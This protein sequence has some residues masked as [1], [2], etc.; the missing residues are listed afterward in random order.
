M[1]RVSGDAKASLNG[2]ELLSAGFSV[3]VPCAVSG[4]TPQPLYCERLLRVLPGKRL[5]FL[6]RSDEGLW[7]VKLMARNRRGQQQYQ[8]E[9]EGYHALRSANLAVPEML[10][11]ADMRDQQICFVAYR[12]LQQA[13]TLSTLLSECDAGASQALLQPLFALVGR[14]HQA[15]LYQQD[16]HLDNFMLQEGVL[17]TLDNASLVVQEGALSTAQAVKNLGLLLA[18]FAP[19]FDAPLTSSLSAYQVSRGEAIPQTKLARAAQKLRLRRARRYL[20]KVLRASSAHLCEQDWQHR[21][22][23]R[24]A[25]SKPAMQEF[26]ANPDA[27]IA[28]GHILKAGNSATVARVQIGTEEYVVKRY[29]IKN[30]WHRIKRAFTPSRAARSW[31]YGHLL[32]LLEVNTPAP[33]A[34]LE[35][36]FG[37]FRGVAYLVCAPLDLDGG[38]F[39]DKKI[40]A[41]MAVAQGESRFAELFHSLGQTHLSHGDLKGSNF[42]LKADQL[43]VLDLDA[44]QLHA[45]SWLARRALAKDRRRF[46]QNWRAPITGGQGE[47]PVSG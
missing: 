1:R 2:P 13:Q 44:M 23:V 28:Q 43:W 21:Q 11:H 41:G 35:R 38:D 25:Y 26:L 18:Q 10:F 4:L 34:L 30:Q 45:C 6:A 40:A 12:Y 31:C 42:F 19:R 14:M 16:I 37:P 24:R 3:P 20:R 8:A 39:L 17:Y 5:V 33:I 9:I 29:N 27:A 32:E 36:R 22:L 47:N 7:V 15:G 46:L